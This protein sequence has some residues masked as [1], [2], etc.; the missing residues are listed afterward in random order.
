MPSCDIQN[1]AVNNQNVVYEFDRTL[2]INFYRS[3]SAMV[4]TR[5]T[6]K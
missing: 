6:F 2:V 4:K 5:I 1:N 3:T